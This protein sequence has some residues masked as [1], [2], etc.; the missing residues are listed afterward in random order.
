MG[1]TLTWL[2]TI[3]G[4]MVGGASVPVGL[5]LL[6]KRMSTTAAIAAPWIGLAAGLITWFVTTWKLSGKIDV[7]TSGNTTNAVA[8]NVTSWGTGVVI[9]V[10]F[11]FLFPG[12]YT[13]TEKSEVERYNKIHGTKTLVGQSNSPANGSDSAPS[14]DAAAEEKEPVA[15]TEKEGVVAS[16]PAPTTIVPSG[17]DVVDFLQ[18]TFIE[19]MDPECSWYKRF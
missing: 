11:S 18:S 4:V 3:L 10:T 17:N 7:T 1:L 15:D 12:K 19:P 8:G 6:W 5:V 14:P 16:N 13:A 2:L 9:A